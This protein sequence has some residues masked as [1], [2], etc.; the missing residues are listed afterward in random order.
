MDENSNAI[1]RVQSLKLQEG[2][3]LSAFILDAVLSVCSFP[4]WCL[5][6]D[7]QIDCILRIAFYLLT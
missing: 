1:P 7:V 4:V 2:A 3:D 5:G 6:Q